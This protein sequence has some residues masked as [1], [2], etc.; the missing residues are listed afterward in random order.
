MDHPYIE[1][2]SVIERYHQG[3]LS[4]EEEEAF[5]AHF[6]ACPACLEELEMARGFRI[7]LR[8]LAAEQ[9]AHLTA[10]VGLAAWLARYGRW[11][12]AGLLAAL[13]LAAVAIPSV[14]L[15]V[16]RGHLR[17]AVAASRAASASWQER[18]EE[19]RSRATSL[20][21]RLEKS[22]R[23]KPGAEAAPEGGEGGESGQPLVNT[24][25]ILLTALRGGP[26]KVPPT[27]QLAPGEGWI[28]LAIPVDPDPRFVGY[29]ATL[30]AG[31][32]PGGRR[33]WHR[34]GLE[35]N[36]LAAIL[37]TFPASALPPGDYR[38]VL[39]GERAEGGAVELGSFPFRV[40][41]GTP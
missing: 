16:V 23:R 19:A 28:S 4:P 11:T 39:A 18:Y 27:V 10:R 38:L 6:V 8:T 37:V 33:L 34:S 9:A 12:Q 31:S 7:G 24:P 22:E 5:E 13:L 15:V 40:S 2:R 21:E 30:T 25:L 17:S 32:D 35:P 41:G 14:L 20:A 36:A 1:E 29:R 3:R 26:G